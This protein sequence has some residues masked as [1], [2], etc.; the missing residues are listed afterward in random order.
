METK[1]QIIFITEALEIYH[2]KKRAVPMRQKTFNGFLND[3]SFYFDCSKL[4]DNEKPWFS[5]SQNTNK[6][7]YPFSFGVENYTTVIKRA[8]NIIKQTFYCNTNL[9]RFI[10]SNN[11]VYYCGEGMIL[12]CLFNPIFMCFIKKKEDNNYD[13][14]FKFSQSIFINDTKCVEKYLVR[15]LIPVIIEKK[16]NFSSYKLKLEIIDDLNKY[17]KKHFQPLCE[18]DVNNANKFLVDNV[19]EYVNYFDYLAHENR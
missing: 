19:E 13:V 9:N 10:D 2:D 12:D 16:D 17:I 5:T 11:N 8:D 18:E 14:I 3:L 4:D 6:S 1:K 15:N 7:S